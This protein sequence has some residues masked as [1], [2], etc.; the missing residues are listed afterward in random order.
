MSRSDSHPAFVLHSR[1]YRETSAIVDLFV[2]ETG[3]VSVVAKGVHRAKS[4]LGATLQPF[5][6]LLVSYA[7]R[8]ELKNLK[9]AE[10]AGEPLRLQGRALFS[11]LYL[12][13]LVARTVQTQYHC[14][15]LFDSYQAALKGLAGSTAVEP[16]L[17]EFELHLLEQLGYGIP[18]PE[19]ILG[20]GGDN[21][22]S[23]FYHKNGHFEEMNGTIR[24]AS[25]SYRAQDLTAI[26]A[27]QFESAATLR[28]AKRLSRQAFEPLLA[29]KS[30]RSRELF[31]TYH[32]EKQ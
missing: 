22:K 30:L 5:Y 1:S 15:E 27:G 11:G 18:F 4:S 28:A 25:R 13:E 8:S 9:S 14:E 10:I 6:P 17:R 31:R 32:Q 20:D 23:F 2:P 26:A 19:V 12:N 16:I 21:T 3:R 29:G 24:D 7:G